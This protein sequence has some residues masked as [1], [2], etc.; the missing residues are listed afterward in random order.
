MV[1][2]FK[3]T[4]DNHFAGEYAKSEDYHA[5]L[6]YGDIPCSDIN[7]NEIRRKTREIHFLH[8]QSLALIDLNFTPDQWKVIFETKL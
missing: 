6:L 3:K 1:E 5:S 2:G 8:I 7:L 4:T